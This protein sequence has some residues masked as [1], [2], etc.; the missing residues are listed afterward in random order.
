MPT[1]T[2]QDRS[3]TANIPARHQALGIQKLKHGLVL[4]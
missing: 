2:T 3:D 1:Q 4:V